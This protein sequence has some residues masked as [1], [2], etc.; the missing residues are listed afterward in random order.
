MTKINEILRRAGDFELCDG[1]FCSFANTDNTL[2]ADRYEEAERIVT[3]VW[4]ATGIIE[5]GGFHYLFESDFNGDLG[6][7][8]TA[9]AFKV[10]GAEA[11]YQAFTQVMSHFSKGLPSDIKKR[12]KLYEEIPE[13]ETNRIN[14]LFWSDLKNIETQLA[15]YIRLN[16]E[17]VKRI[18]AATKKN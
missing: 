18:L 17:N 8:L 15:R 3:L 2:H 11:A 7:K 9:E 1:V 6:Y 12:L 14:T 4:H 13:E 10:I 5:N 16:S